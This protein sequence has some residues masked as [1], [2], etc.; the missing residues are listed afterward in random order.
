MT[1][2]SLC[3]SLSFS[4]SLPHSLSLPLFTS[5][6]LSL[7]LLLSSSFCSFF[8]LHFTLVV[9]PASPSSPTFNPLS[10]LPNS[11]MWSSPHSHFPLF[12]RIPSQVFPRSLAPLYKYETFTACGYLYIKHQ[13]KIRHLSH[14]F[15]YRGLQYK[16][17][18]WGSGHLRQRFSPRGVDT[19]YQLWRTYSWPSSLSLSSLSLRTLSFRC[20]FGHCPTPVTCSSSL[21]YD[22]GNGYVFTI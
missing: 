11:V 4:P 13:G 17:S 7:S 9:S 8:S 6:F 10:S 2:D 15:S 14:S 1:R 22:I 12:P 19:T 18:R 5:L 20:S 21:S 3:P 16:L